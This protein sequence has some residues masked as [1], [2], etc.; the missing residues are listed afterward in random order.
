MA[1]IGKDLSFGF[2]SLLKRPGFAVVAILTL[3]VGIGANTTIFGVVDTV[4][5][6]PLPYHESHRLVRV[7]PEEFMTKGWL[8]SFEEAESFESI[9]GASGHSATLTG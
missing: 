7:W 6:S 2:R 9:A 4:L 5:M 8:M 3:A 1:W